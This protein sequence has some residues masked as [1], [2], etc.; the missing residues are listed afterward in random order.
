MPDRPS[1]VLFIF[2]DSREIRH[3]PEPPRVGSRVRSRHRSVWYV[4]QLIDNGSDT[5]VAICVGLARVAAAPQRPVGHVSEKARR[6][7]RE[8]SEKDPAADLL[9]RVK[10]VVSPRA[11]RRRWQYR[12]YLP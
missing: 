2:P 6:D 3:L 5:Y 4:A 10:D 8:P 9:Q 11:L 12:N 1:T 7:E